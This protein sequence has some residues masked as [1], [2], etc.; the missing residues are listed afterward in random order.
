[1]KLLSFYRREQPKPEPEPKAARVIPDC[2]VCGASMPFLRESFRACCQRYM[3]A[4][5]ACDD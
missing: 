3:R 5:D 4:L 2:P 1:M